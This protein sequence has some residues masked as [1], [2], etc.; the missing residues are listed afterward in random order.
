MTEAPVRS[1]Y[2]GS[3]SGGNGMLA[4]MHCDLSVLEPHLALPVYSVVLA[5]AKIEGE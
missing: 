3:S 4:V 1:Q 2:R 5:G